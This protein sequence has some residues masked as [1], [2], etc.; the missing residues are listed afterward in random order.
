LSTVVVVV[1][2]GSAAG[3]VVLGGAPTGA[4]VAGGAVLG[5]ACVVFGA[6]CDAIVDAVD[7]FALAAQVL[8]RIS[9]ASKPAALAAT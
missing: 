4:V 7:S 1:L 2:G 3:A 9:T 5:G 6:V 8:M